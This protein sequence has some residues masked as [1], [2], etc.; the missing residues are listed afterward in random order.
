MPTASFVNRSKSYGISLLSIAPLFLLTPVLSPAME[1]SPLCQTAI[2]SGIA[3]QNPSIYKEGWIDLNK[4][5]AKNIYEDPSQPVEKRVEDL[6]SRMNREEKLGQ[7][8]QGPQTAGD[9]QLILVSQGGLGSYPVVPET[10]LRNALQ[11]AAVE[12]SR[13]GIP[14]LFADE[15]LVAPSMRPVGFRNMDRITD[16]ELDERVAQVLRAKI[17]AGLFEHPY[18]KVKC[19]ELPGSKGV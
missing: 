18:V 9:A 7:L 14:L 12:D 3:S 8:R 15:T 10:E 13:L 11:R 2:E 16:Q 1:K 5:G 4:D 19:T 17:A 6:L